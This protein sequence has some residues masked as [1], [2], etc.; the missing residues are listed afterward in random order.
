MQPH[1]ISLLDE[2]GQG[3]RRS[4]CSSD[5]SQVLVSEA[6]EQWVEFGLFDREVLSV[7]DLPTGFFKLFGN[8]FAE[9]AAPVGVLTI[10][11]GSLGFRGPLTCSDGVF[12]SSDVVLGEFL[13]LRP[14][15]CRPETVRF[16]IGIEFLVDHFRGTKTEEVRNLVFG[17]DFHDCYGNR[18]VP[19]QY[20]SLNAILYDCLL[21]GAGRPFRI[22][23]RIDPH[24]L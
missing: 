22:G 20:A 16:L 14:A 24:R 15:F 5:Q 6:I 18:A 8:A 17:C 7:H 3:R 19:V 4:T 1:L 12:Q 11:G 10:D 21:I 13:R 2:G 9:A 23:L